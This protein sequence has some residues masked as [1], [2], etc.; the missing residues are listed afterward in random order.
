MFHALAIV[1]VTA[2]YAYG[3]IVSMGHARATVPVQQGRNVW[4]VH[5]L[6]FLHARTTINATAKSVQEEIVSPG[7]ARATMRVQQGRRV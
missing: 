5:V 3:G 7:R 4:V 1:N 6:T 2:N